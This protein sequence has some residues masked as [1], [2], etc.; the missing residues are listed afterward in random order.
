MLKDPSP[1]SQAQLV[2]IPLLATE[3]SVKLITL[4]SQLGKVCV[5]FAVGNW[6]TRIVPDKLFCTQVPVVVTV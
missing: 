3:A 1:K 2:K 4:V 6:L 5:K